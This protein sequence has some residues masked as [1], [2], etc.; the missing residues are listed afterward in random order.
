MGRIA[1][2]QVEDTPGEGI[3]TKTAG[4]EYCEWSGKRILE[5]HKQSAKDR[6]M[7]IASVKNNR[8]L[9]EVLALSE[10]Q[11][12]MIADS[13][14]LIEL[15]SGETLIEKGDPVTVLCILQEGL[16]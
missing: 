6:E 11:L 10:K 2:N 15:P 1:R 5:N 9:G 8:V 14:Y 4:L 13:V 12:E 16:L 3:N 7:I